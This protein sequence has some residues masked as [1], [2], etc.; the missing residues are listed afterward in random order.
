MENDEE[1]RHEKQTRGQKD[2][3]ASGEKSNTERRGCFPQIILLRREA[4]EAR[5]NSNG[6]SALMFYSLGTVMFRAYK[7]KEAKE[8]Y[9]ANKQGEV[10]REEIRNNRQ[11]SFNASM[12]LRTMQMI[13]NR[14]AAS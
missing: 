5:L 11:R 3:E 12:A 1:G 6:K 10:G 7:T 4:E 14:R 8:N 13:S 2:R 9:E